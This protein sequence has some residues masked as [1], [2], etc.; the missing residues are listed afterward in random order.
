MSKE[1]WKARKVVIVGAGAVG[2]TFALGKSETLLAKLNNFLLFSS[3]QNIGEKDVPP[4]ILRSQKRNACQSR[5][6]RP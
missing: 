2:S 6:L 3:G 5:T 4:T 1:E